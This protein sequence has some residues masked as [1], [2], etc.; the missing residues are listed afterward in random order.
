VSRFVEAVAWAAGDEQNAERAKAGK[1]SAQRLDSGGK[2][3][4]WP[5]LAKLLGEPTGE[6][7]VGKIR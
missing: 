6:A 5:T 1:Y 2:A 7:V 4:G 3:T